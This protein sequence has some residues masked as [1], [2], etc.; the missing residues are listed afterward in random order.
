MAT[1]RLHGDRVDVPGLGVVSYALTSEGGRTVGVEADSASGKAHLSLVLDDAMGLV[2]VPRIVRDDLLSPH[3]EGICR[4]AL[5]VLRGNLGQFVIAIEDRIALDIESMGRR[6]S[7]MDAERNTGAMSEE[8]VSRAAS[9]AWANGTRFGALIAA[10]RAMNAYASGPVSGGPLPSFAQDGG[11]PLAGIE[12]S[13]P[14]TLGGGIVDALDGTVSVVPNGT[15]CVPVHK[16]ARFA[17]EHGYNGVE[18]FGQGDALGPSWDRP[19]SGDVNV[20]PDRFVG[21]LI[22]DKTIDDDTLVTVGLVPPTAAMLRDFCGRVSDAGVDPV[23]LAFDASLAY[24]GRARALLAE[25]DRDL[26][27]APMPSP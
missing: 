7:A 3:L 16:V 14:G 21:A 5:D 24:V 11:A 17:R 23:V 15:R 1:I 13:R 26:G 12:R 2:V 9:V 8:A 20:H 27:H 4:G 22:A 10:N 18:S 6:M 19:W 25:L